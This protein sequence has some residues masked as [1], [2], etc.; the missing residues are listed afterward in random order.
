MIHSFPRL[1]LLAQSSVRGLQLPFTHRTALIEKIDKF[2]YY[3]SQP[4]FLLLNSYTQLMENCLIEVQ[5]NVVGVVWIFSWV[6]NMLYSISK[7]RY[8]GKDIFACLLSCAWRNDVEPDFILSQWK[9]LWCS[10]WNLFIMHNL[11]HRCLYSIHL[12][13]FLIINLS[14]VKVGKSQQH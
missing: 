11:A 13:N 14:Y 5:S 3:L 9:R 10:L 4:L 12:S 8:R 7:E 6:L 1:E 2:Y